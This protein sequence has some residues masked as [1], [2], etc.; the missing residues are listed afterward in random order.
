M[1]LKTSQLNLQDVTIEHEETL[2]QGFFRLKRLRLKHR[3]FQGGWSDT[4]ERELFAKSLAVSA[5]VYDP[6]LDLVGLVEQFRVGTLASPYGPWTLEGV[7]GMVEQGETPEDVITRELFEEAGLVARDLLAITGFYPTPGSC[8]EY[9][10]LFCA[11]CD[12]S[13][14]GGNFG[15]AHEGEDILF[16][17]YPAEDVFGAMLENKTDNAATLIGLMWLQINRPNLRARHG[18]KTLGDSAESGEVS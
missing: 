11:L 4:I 10:H 6:V 12:L 14:A 15:L 1:T 9:T 18:Q 7:A 16:R 17:A 13:E 2:H 8:D 3:L 5:I